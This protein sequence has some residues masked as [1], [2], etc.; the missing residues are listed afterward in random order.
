MRWILAILTLFGVGSVEAESPPFSH[1]LLDGVLQAYVDEA[2]RIDYAALKKARA[3]LDTY[4]ERLS[5]TSPH[6]NPDLFPCAQHQLAYWINAYNACVLRGVLDAF[7]VK[8]VADIGGL[9]GFF[10]EAK[11]TIGSEKMTLDDIE[12][13]II[14]PRYKDPRIHFAVNCAA[15]SCPA[16]GRSAFTGEN[17]DAQLD[18]ATRK[19]LANPLHVRI[20]RAANTVHLT[21]IMEWFK[22][23]FVE[24]IPRDQGDVPEQATLLDYLKLYLAGADAKYVAEHPDLGIVFT[25]YDWASN[26]SVAKAP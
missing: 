2:G 23:D 1:D 12:N 8:S 20:D 10:K 22:G 9:D 19:A 4:L 11:Y 7:P 17:L 5:Q 25:E 14:R 26:A 21:K 3:P 16:L 24:W 15:R 18:A 6:S 13:T